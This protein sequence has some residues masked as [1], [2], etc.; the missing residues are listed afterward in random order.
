MGDYNTVEKTTN[1]GEPSRLAI[2]HL[3]YLGSLFSKR[4]SMKQ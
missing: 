1:G 4:W 2:L 3:Y